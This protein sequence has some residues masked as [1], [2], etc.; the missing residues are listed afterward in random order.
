MTDD[1]MN[2]LKDLRK[3]Y[4]LLAKYNGGEDY[5]AFKVLDMT[6]KELSTPEESAREWCK[7]NGYVMMRES[8]YEQAIT[9][10]YFEGQNAS[11]SEIPNKW[12]PVSERLPEYGKKVLVTI[13]F[14]DD[15]AK[16]RISENDKYGF[17]CGNVS[18]WM[19]L[20]ESY[21]PQE[22]EGTK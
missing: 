18:A 5:I 7:Q 9:K 3:E 12:I 14:F 22:S 4:E 16:V 11:T 6:I 1:G 13:N 8:D 17:L 15:G 19:P 2:K 21:K 20:P 10:A